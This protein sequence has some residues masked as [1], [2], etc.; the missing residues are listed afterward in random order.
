MISHSW[1][2]YGSSIL[3]EWEFY[4]GFCG[5]K[6]TREPGEKPSK[7][8]DSQRQPQPTHGTGA[9][10]EP[11]PHIL[12]RDESHHCAIAA[13]LYDLLENSPKKARALIVFV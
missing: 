2:S 12:V 11:G 6:K 7:Q 13:S 9:G 4:V 5:G 1:F 3:V 10:M 8:G